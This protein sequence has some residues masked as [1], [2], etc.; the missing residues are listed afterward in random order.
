ME[1]EKLIYNILSCIG[2]IIGCI[3]IFL[4]KPNNIYYNAL[5]FFLVIAIFILEG[6]I[7]YQLHKLKKKTK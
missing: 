1:N 3:L 7:F 5:D 2:F 6:K 4:V